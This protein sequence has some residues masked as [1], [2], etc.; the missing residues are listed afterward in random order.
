[1]GEKTGE[2]IGKID[3][4]FV[5][6]ARKERRFL[7]IDWNSAEVK[8]SE[9]SKGGKSLSADEIAKRVKDNARVKETKKANR[10]KMAELRADAAKA[11]RKGKVDDVAD[12]T[13][14]IAKLETENAE[15]VR[16]SVP[17]REKK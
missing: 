4:K 8:M 17:K 13:E 15:L 7:Y 12:I 1:M 11:A 5:E 9:P 16:K 14:K 3:P 2:V 6:R 10:K